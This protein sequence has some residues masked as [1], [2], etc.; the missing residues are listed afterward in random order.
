MLN[1]CG[2]QYSEFNRIVSIELSHNLFLKCCIKYITDNLAIV[3]LNT[4]PSR[5]F[6]SK[7]NAF[8][9]DKDKCSDSLIFIY[10]KRCSFRYSCKKNYISVSLEFYK[11]NYHQFYWESRETEASTKHESKTQTNTVRGWVLTAANTL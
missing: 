1:Y 4:R 10:V 7:K 11:K 9:I 3:Y 6:V 5:Q 8:V 2:T